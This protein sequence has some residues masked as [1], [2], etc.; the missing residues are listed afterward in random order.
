MPNLT[1]RGRVRL[2]YSIMVK[3]EIFSDFFWSLS[4]YINYDNRP[5]DA[6][7][8]TTDWSVT[9]GLGYSF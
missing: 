8:A 2:N 4:F 9:T 3:Q 1:D 7:S 6:N 5:P